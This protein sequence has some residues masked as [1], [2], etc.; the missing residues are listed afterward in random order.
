MS[1]EAGL[2]FIFRG[3]SPRQRKACLL[4]AQVALAQTCHQL[5]LRWKVNTKRGFCPGRPTDTPYLATMSCAGLSSLPEDIL[6]DIYHRVAE[7]C[8]ERDDGFRQCC[9]LAGALPCFSRL[10]LPIA[11]LTRWAAKD[12][13]WEGK[14]ARILSCASQSLAHSMCGSLLKLCD[15]GLLATLAPT[16][17]GA[18]IKW[19]LLRQP[20]VSLVRIVVLDDNWRDTD[21][22]FEGLRFKRT[23][24]GQMREE[25]KEDDVEVQ[26]LMEV[27]EDERGFRALVCT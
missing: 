1:G 18:G 14:K 11:P 13:S 6:S 23:W 16:Q 8:L 24:K 10:S 21:G 4:P 19:A 5:H 25:Q 22:D 7:E 26:A 20:S 12:L 17:C 15:P 2:S 9:K 27:S 3:A